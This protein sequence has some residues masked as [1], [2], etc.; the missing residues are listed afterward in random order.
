MST[1]LIRQPRQVVAL[2]SSQW[3]SSIRQYEAMLAKNGFDVRKV[4]ENTLTFTVRAVAGRMVTGGH[5]FH[6]MQA[7]E[8]QNA[9]TLWLLQADIDFNEF[10]DPNLIAVIAEVSTHFY[11][12]LIDLFRFW[13][14]TDLQIRNISLLDWAGEDL[15]IELIG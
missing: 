7:S 10:T 5:R 15:F 14:L 12:E 6:C 4:L 8:Y 1:A 11:Q 13:G 3:F 2:P 9:L